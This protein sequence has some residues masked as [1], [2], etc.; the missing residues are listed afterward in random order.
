M[1]FDQTCNFLPDPLP[2][3]S[4][5]RHPVHNSLKHHALRH[6]DCQQ[7]PEIKSMNL[8]RE[9]QIRRPS[10]WSNPASGH[11]KQRTPCR[12]DPGNRNPA[13]KRTTV[14]IERRVIRHTSRICSISANRLCTWLRLDQHVDRKPSKW[15]GRSQLLA[16]NSRN[17]SYVHKRF[18]RLRAASKIDE[19]PRLQG[20]RATYLLVGIT[21]SQECSVLFACGH[22]PPVLNSYRSVNA[23][24]DRAGLY[25]ADRKFDHMMTLPGQ[26]KRIRRPESIILTTLRTALARTLRS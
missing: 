11:L 1:P 19:P 3:S 13:V 17:R 2:G 23:F 4:S 6:E 24:G 14:L 20:S 18:Q 26:G 16:A 12:N 15:T 25:E 21:I 10:A 22:A 7:S 5:T 8:I 9:W